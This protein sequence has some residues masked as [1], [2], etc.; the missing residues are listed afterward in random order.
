MNGLFRRY[1]ADLYHEHR[2]QPKNVLPIFMYPLALKSN[3][4]TYKSHFNN[5]ILFLMVN[6]IM[7][8]RWYLNHRKLL[9]VAIFN[10]V[11]V[12]SKIGICNTMVSAAMIWKGK[13]K[14]HGI[15][16]YKFQRLQVTFKVVALLQ[17]ALI[18]TMW[19]KNSYH[20]FHI[21]FDKHVH[22]FWEYEKFWRRL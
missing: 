4:S 16:T 1:N 14:L 2:L 12:W 18:F 22:F 3:F 7:I 11:W 9:F 20:P 6:S 19:S 17:H 13:F 15:T 10:K 21:S 8:S 5:F